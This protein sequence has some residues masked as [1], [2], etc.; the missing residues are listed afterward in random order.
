MS[1]HPDGSGTSWTETAPDVNQPHG[2]DY[3]SLQDLRIGVRK[4][5]EQEHATF[6]DATVG[7]IHTPGGAA[8]LG[9]EDGTATII[10]DGTLKGHGIVWDGTEALWCSTAA[11]GASTTGDF[12]IVQMN[13]NTQWKGGDITWAGQMAFQAACDFSAVDI[14][15]SLDVTGALACGSTATITNL[16]TCSS[17]AAIVNDISCNAGLEVDG[18][19][20][21]N[22]NV[23]VDGTF[24]F[25]SGAVFNYLGDWSGRAMD[26][27][28]TAATDGEVYVF[29]RNNNLQR[30]ITASTPHG[31][32]RQVVRTSA[33]A[34][35]YRSFSM[36]VKKGNTWSISGDTTTYTDPTVN[37]IPFGDNT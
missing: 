8:I 37:W 27:T 21:L 7:G 4:R 20:L 2:L 28:Y 14:S 13:P 6:A 18:T 16:L 24:T 5:I 1:V 26:T 34:D 10:A 9:I 32:R 3:R 36:K 23:I 12:T 29:V 22:G 33:G 31:T 30:I 25:G 19:A 17:K 15:D 35:E 11:A